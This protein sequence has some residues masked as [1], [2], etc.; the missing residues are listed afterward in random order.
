MTAELAALA[1]TYPS[2]LVEEFVNVTAELA[3]VRYTPNEVPL[4]LLKM[5][6]KSLSA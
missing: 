2:F 5:I 3:N 1:S 6:G 4:L